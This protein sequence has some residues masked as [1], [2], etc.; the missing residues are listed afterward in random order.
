MKTKGEIVISVIGTTILT[1]SVIMIFF[2]LITIK[3]HT[4]KRNIDVV[5]FH[6]E[7]KYSISYVN[8][9]NEIINES[10]WKCVN[11][12]IIIDVPKG[13][14]MYYE[15]KYS[16]NSFWGCMDSANSY[17]KIHVHSINDIIGADWNHGKF[18][19]G[20]TNRIR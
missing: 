14:K 8:N 17:V 12:K 1:I 13:E 5:W 19:T 18:G 11:P 9:A 15:Y 7:N 16:F 4:G 10:P 3:I 2:S 20:K 6:E